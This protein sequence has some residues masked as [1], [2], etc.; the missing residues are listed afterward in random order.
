MSNKKNYKKNYK[1]KR[2]KDEIRA[3]WIGV[4]IS[5]A[6]HKEHIALLESKNEKIRKSIKKGYQDDNF[7]DVSKRFK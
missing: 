1:N 7:K 2:S 5:S 4:G 3:Y 6:V